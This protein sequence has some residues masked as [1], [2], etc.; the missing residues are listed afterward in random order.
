LGFEGLDVLVPV[1]VDVLESWP[2]VA[3]Y[4]RVEAHKH[5]SLPRNLRVEIVYEFESNH[6]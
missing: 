1:L 2:E 5:I 4:F 3:A 6:V